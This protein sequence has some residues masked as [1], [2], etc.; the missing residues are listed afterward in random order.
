MKVIL[1]LVHQQPNT[2]TTVQVCHLVSLHYER[3]LSIC[4][5]RTT[6]W[7]KKNSCYYKPKI[8]PYVYMKSCFFCFCFCF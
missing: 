6:F 7:E 5:T 1:Q 2:D 8:F 4:M 3:T